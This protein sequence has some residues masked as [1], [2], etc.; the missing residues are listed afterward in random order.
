MFGNE[1]MNNII[2]C[3]TAQ[4]VK[5]GWVKQSYFEHFQL[6]LGQG[7]IFH[8]GLQ[9][10]SNWKGSYRRLSYIHTPFTTNRTKQNSIHSYVQ[11]M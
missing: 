4:V 1:A 9:F 5:T 7:H 11:Y 6:W 2:T 10:L 8:L 3:N